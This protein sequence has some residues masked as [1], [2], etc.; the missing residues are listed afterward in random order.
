MILL[1]LMP[2]AAGLLCRAAAPLARHYAAPL[3]RAM[4]RYRYYATCRFTPPAPP[5][6]AGM[7]DIM[8]ALRRRA[9]RQRR[10]LRAAYRLRFVVICLRHTFASRPA[11]SKYAV[12]SFII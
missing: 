3:S 5:R 9:R 12:S 2:R 8:F 1:I 11:T 4:L 7:F 6:F 10:R